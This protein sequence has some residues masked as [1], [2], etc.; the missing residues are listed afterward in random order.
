MSEIVYVEHDLSHIHHD[1]LFSQLCFESL[2]IRDVKIFK[3]VYYICFPINTLEFCPELV[4]EQ[5]IDCESSDMNSVRLVTCILDW[6]LLFLL[7]PRSVALPQYE[8][9]NSSSS[10]PSACTSGNV[11]VRKEW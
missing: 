1:G 4:R 5:T 11:R 8:T 3:F 10:I 6:L 9:T 7:V 2:I